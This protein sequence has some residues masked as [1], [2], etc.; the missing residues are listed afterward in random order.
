MYYYNGAYTSSVIHS[1]CHYS[2][3]STVLILTQS[4]YETRLPIHPQGKHSPD[5]KLLS[6]RPTS[7]DR[8]NRP[9]KDESG[10][11]LVTYSYFTH[12]SV[13]ASALLRHTLRVMWHPYQSVCYHAFCCIGRITICTV[14]VLS[15][16][17]ASPTH[18]T[19]YS[20]IIKQYG[21]LHIFAIVS[22]HFICCCIPT[23]VP[24]DCHTLLE[25]LIHVIQTLLAFPW[26]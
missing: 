18:L 23:L 22:P 1:H 8:I 25:A 7:R 21:V 15:W 17:L 26:L 19:F 16:R 11:W 3:T 14:C 6:D 5:V 13:T 10:Q 12:C 24:N 4:A 9:S 20:A 2:L